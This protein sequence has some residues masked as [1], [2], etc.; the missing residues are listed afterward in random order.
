M[1]KRLPILYPLICKGVIKMY[2]AEKVACSG[3]Q[4][5]LPTSKNLNTSISPN[6]EGQ[7]RVTNVKRTLESTIPKLVDF[8]GENELF[9]FS[10]LESFH[11]NP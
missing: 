2:T 11:M 3:L 4:L 8:F 9:F 5:T 1:Q 7:S 6:S 10:Y